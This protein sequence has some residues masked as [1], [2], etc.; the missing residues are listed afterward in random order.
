[1]ISS[2]HAVAKG[3]ITTPQQLHICYCHTP[4]RYAWDLYHL[5]RKE[6]GLDRGVRGLLSGFLLHYLRIW[7]AVSA[8]RVDRFIANSYCVARRI[9][10]TY[11][12]EAPVIYPPVDVHRFCISPEKDDY[13]VAVSR[14]VPYKRMDLIV[15]A[16]AAM[17][18]KKLIVIGGG[19]GFKK[20]QAAAPK[21]VDVRG[22]VPFEELRHCLQRA[23]ALVFAAEED[24]GIVP[25]EA[26]ACGTPV[27]AYGRGGCEES[28]VPLRSDGRGREGER[29]ATGVFFH[30]QRR[31]ALI[32][33]VAFFER[34]QEAFDAQKIRQHSL[35]FSTERFQQEFRAFVEQ[36]AS[37]H[38]ARG[39][40]AA[41]FPDKVS[42]RP[43]AAPAVDKAS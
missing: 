41:S 24:F 34:N 9:R 39:Y 38:F 1:V 2:S 36:A 3:V 21:N 6:T 29:P 12:R 19:P 22:T 35:Q 28:V 33:A 10:K 17:P 20:I 31:E 18:D 37:E 13:Y 16:F 32:S 15:E 43:V 23:K 5:Y 30:E 7:D 25:V 40:R 14:M 11:G 27:I 8:Q 4:L 42:L 26:Q